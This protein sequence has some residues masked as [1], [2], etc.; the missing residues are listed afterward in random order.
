[1]SSEGDDMT[2][3][4]TY[5]ASTGTQ[6]ALPPAGLLLMA[7]GV[8]A[9]VLAGV[10]LIV[11][12]ADAAQGPIGLGTAESFAVLAGSTVTN[13]GPSVVSGVLG[14]S[15]GSAVAAAGAL[16]ISLGGLLIVT[17]RRRS[18]LGHRWD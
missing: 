1:M 7:V 2:A 11:N 16:A 3:R 5:V 12:R 4:E 18:G 15:P 17:S 10:G 14:V 9:L 8:I 6:G 13:T